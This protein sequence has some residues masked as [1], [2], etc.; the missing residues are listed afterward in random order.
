MIATAL[1][2]SIILALA[3]ALLVAES[4]GAGA[5]SDEHF[6]TSIQKL[7]NT[8]SADNARYTRLASVVVT[9][10]D[11]TI[12]MRPVPYA[13]RNEPYA[14]VRKKVDKHAQLWRTLT[15]YINEKKRQYE[16]SND[17]K[18]A[19]LKDKYA[20]GKFDY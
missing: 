18:S 1:L 7:N 3:T 4:R 16:E 14:S 8:I 5:A 13:A 6:T 11:D 20:T 12:E 19:N 10:E 15:M 2:V 17:P 9:E